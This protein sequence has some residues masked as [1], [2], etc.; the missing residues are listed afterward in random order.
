MSSCKKLRD[1]TKPIPEDHT[2]PLCNLDNKE[3]ECIKY[4]CKCKI[5]AI[6]CIWPDCICSYC[7]KH[8]NK[9]EC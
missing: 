9:C 1:F 8:Q 4:E 6:N 5:L 3:C 7:L 2:C